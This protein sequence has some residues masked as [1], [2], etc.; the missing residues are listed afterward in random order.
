MK[1]SFRTTVLIAA[2]VGLVGCLFLSGRAEAQDIISNLE[3]AK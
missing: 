1:I 2:L 3:I